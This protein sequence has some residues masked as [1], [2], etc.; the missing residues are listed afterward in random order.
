MATVMLPTKDDI[1]QLIA[2]VEAQK[3]LPY[4][5]F[6][7]EEADSKAEKLKNLLPLYDVGLGGL[8]IKEVDIRIRAPSEEGPSTGSSKDWQIHTFKVGGEYELLPVDEVDGL[9]TV[10]NVKEIRAHV[11]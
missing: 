1:E 6:T 5:M 8:S 9:P 7:D 2:L 4:G 10:W 3:D 11:N